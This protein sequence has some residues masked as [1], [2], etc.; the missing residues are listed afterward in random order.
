MG[1]PGHPP[2]FQFIFHYQQLGSTKPFMAEGGCWLIS[3]ASENARWDV[4]GLWQQGRR[5]RGR[6]DQEIRWR[7][8]DV[9]WCQLVSIFWMFFFHVFS[10]PAHNMSQ[11]NICISFGGN[12]P[13]PQPPHFLA[14]VWLFRGKPQKK[15]PL[16]NVRMSWT[17][18]W[19]RS[20]AFRS[21]FD[22]GR[23]FWFS[24]RQW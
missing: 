11:M 13:S 16:R 14:K 15:V 1:S 2:Q 9:Q 20:F 6:N 4:Q 5:G 22:R 21:S 24:T 8:N 19:F 10:A 12:L 3:I 17:W 7:L 23:W 18:R